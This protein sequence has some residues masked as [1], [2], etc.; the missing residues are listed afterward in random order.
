LTPA[1]RA[2]MPRSPPHPAC[3]PPACAA[4]VADLCRRVLFAAQLEGWQLGK[5]RVFL[6]AGQLAQLEV[7]WRGWRHVLCTCIPALN[8]YPTS[9]RVAR[10]RQAWAGRAELRYL[11][12]RLGL[13][14]RM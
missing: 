12:G 13:G 9:L 14:A 4:Q 10:G 8:A 3:I 6:R 1:N 11:L 2:H 5:S 7:S